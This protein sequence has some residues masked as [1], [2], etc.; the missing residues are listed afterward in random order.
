M[1]QS[2]SYEDTAR[3]PEIKQTVYVT[4]QLSVVQFYSMENAS[5]SSA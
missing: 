4:M 1:Q 2:P 3:M 5:L